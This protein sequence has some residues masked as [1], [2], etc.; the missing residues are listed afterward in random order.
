[1]NEPRAKGVSTNSFCGK[2]G[3]TLMR[4]VRYI[5]ID[6]EEECRSSDLRSSGGEKNYPNCCN[7]P[8]DPIPSGGELLPCPFCGELPIIKPDFPEKQGNGWAR[9][10]CNNQECYARPSIEHFEDFGEDSSARNKR[11]VRQKWNTRRQPLPEKPKG[12]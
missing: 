12:E 5:C 7:P 8:H 4:E 9:I 10:E 11:R 6:C 1:M 2:H 3:T